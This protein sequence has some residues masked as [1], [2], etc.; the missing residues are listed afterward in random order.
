[1]WWHNIALAAED[2]EQSA[3]SAQNNK[4]KRR[5]ATSA[6]RRPA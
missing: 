1:M 4:A 2:A 5:E 3:Q 6:N